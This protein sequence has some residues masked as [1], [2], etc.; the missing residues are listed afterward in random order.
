MTICRLTNT[1]PTKRNA[2]R[3]GSSGSNVSSTNL[4]VS[5]MN[6]ETGD[7]LDSANIFAVQNIIFTLTHAHSSPS[8][9]LS[10]V[11]S[12]PA[13]QIASDDMCRE[14]LVGLLVVLLVWKS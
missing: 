10:I 7:K 13:Y 8:Q 4:H 3:S 6:N 1:P 11:E 2:R 5:K 9:P 12:Y 14:F